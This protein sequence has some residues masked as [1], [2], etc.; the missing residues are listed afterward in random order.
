MITILDD[1]NRV[2]FHGDKAAG[3]SMN[4]TPHV[5]PQLRTHFAVHRNGLLVNVTKL[6]SNVRTYFC[7]CLVEFYRQP[8]EGA[9]HW[10]QNTEL[11]GS[12][13]VPLKYHH[14]V[15]KAVPG[16]ARK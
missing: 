13:R 3:R 5:R 11:I 4:Q 15:L 6:S 12:H 7:A 8:P 2:S 1:G 14:P 9:K 10:H 16:S